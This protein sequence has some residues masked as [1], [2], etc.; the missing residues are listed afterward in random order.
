[1]WLPVLTSNVY[2]MPEIAGDAA[3]L[4]NPYSTNQIAEAMYKLLTDS[5]LWR[6]KRQK[7]LRRVRQFTWKKA[8]YATFK[9]Y[10]KVVSE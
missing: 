9:V 5:K 8:A 1:M 2:S 4:V 10:E 7:S 3:V 6:E